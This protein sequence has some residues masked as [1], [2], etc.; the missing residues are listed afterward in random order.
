MVTVEKLA[1]SIV[2]DSLRPKEYEPV[3]VSTYPHTLELAEQIGLECQKAGAD[4][5]LVVDTDK[6]F[7]GQFKNFSE[8]NLKKVSAHCIGIAE[9][10]RSYVYLGGPRDPGPMARVPQEKFAAM[11]RGEQAHDEKNREKKP[12]N[13][14]VTLGSVTRERA[15]VYGYN[16]AKWKKSV[17]EAIAVNYGKLEAA[18]ARAEAHLSQPADVR[19]TADNGTDLRFRLAG[20]PRA[21]H[22][23]D[24]VIS[25]A[26]LAAD[27]RNASLPAGEATV[28]PIEDSAR[29]TFV[30]DLGVP[31]VGRVIEGLSWTFRD[32]RAVEFTA[33]RNVGSAQTGWEGATGDR[34]ALGSFGL[35]LNPRAT[36]GFLQS[37][38][39][40]GAVT[41]GIGENRDLGG[42][43][44]SSYGFAGT[45]VS[46]TVEVGG[47]VV[48]DRGKWVA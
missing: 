3:I 41:I 40:S 36:P 22:V 32:G 4:P 33:K 37:T 34:D 35:G 7:Y 42:K 28:A 9:Y 14:I 39:V 2:H 44:A 29:G 23:N 43:N 27:N 48:I 1:R 6:L 21:P 16:F 8:E 25:D 45:L 12:K 47:K 5:F 15:R 30:C 26:D 46:G 10:A 20:A 38:M 18:A 17:E 19:V 11:F 31:Q 13:V 24:G